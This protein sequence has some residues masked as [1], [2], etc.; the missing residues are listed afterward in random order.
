MINVVTQLP[1]TMVVDLDDQGK[2]FTTP[3]WIPFFNSVYTVCNALSQSGT[4]ANR[5]VKV[6]WT[7][8]MYYDISL[9]KPV[10][11]TAGGWRDATGAVV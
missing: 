8:R 1:N 5:P 9:N 7:G 3:G 2:L 11:Y 10:W 6:L 4:T